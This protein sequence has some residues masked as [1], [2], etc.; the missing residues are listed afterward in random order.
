MKKRL[1]ILFIII[2]FILTGCNKKTEIKE[3]ATKQVTTTISDIT[4]ISNEEIKTSYL[5]I[6]ENYNKYK[7]EKVYEKL[8]YHIKYL[9]E[10]GKYNKDNDLTILANRTSIYIDKPNKKNKQAVIKS[11]SIIEGDEEELIKEI[12]NNYLKQKV[13]KDT[14]KEQTII[15]SADANDKNMLTKE[16]INKAINYLNNHY[17][18]PYKNDEILEKTIYYSIYLNM[19]GKENNDI[20]QLGKNMINYLSTSDKEAKDNVVQLINKI[21][22]KQKTNVDNYYNEIIRNK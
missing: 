18:N 19:I 12:Y 20:T 11:L 9:Q 10:L 5:Y 2:L 7:D 21:T 15:A 22:K 8:L 6:K 14:I 13:V 1:F 16:N 3:K 17:Q 4:N